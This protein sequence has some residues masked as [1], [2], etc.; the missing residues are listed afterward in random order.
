MI[1]I[2]LLPPEKRKAG[3]TPLPRF[4]LIVI[5]AAA[6]V[7]FGAGI[8]FYALIKIPAINAD[9]GEQ[10]W[11][12]GNAFSLAD[13]TIGSALGYLDLR[14]PDLDW[15]SDNPNLLRLYDKLM[16]RQSFIDTVPHD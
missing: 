8:A 5:N 16:Q 15:R 10:P 1:K 7:L 12:H 6:L 9:I 13:I 11:C 4:F 3:R 2:N 14:L